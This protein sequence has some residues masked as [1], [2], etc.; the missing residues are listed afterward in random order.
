M[1]ELD[2]NI[3]LNWWKVL[4]KNKGGRAELR[5]AHN[6]TEIA[7]IEVYHNLYKQM[8]S[9]DKESLATVAG[10]CAHVK[11]HEGGCLAEQM[12]ENLSTLRF[13]RLLAITDRNEMYHAMVR[14]V[15]MLGGAVN[16]LDLAETVYWWNEYTKKRL[17]Y[18][19]YAKA[20]E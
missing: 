7:F 1:S 4:E 20:K 19:Y 14:L 15:K 6:L 3:V 9:A 10:V 18:D 11:A 17:A 12:A 2:F 8:K 5:R 16:I 13:R